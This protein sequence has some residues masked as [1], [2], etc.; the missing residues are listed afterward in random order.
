MTAPLRLT[1]QERAMVAAFEARHG[2]TACP[3]CTFSTDPTE[4]L[5]WREII[6]R[7]QAAGKLAYL[8]KLRAEASRRRAK[9]AE[10]ARMGLPKAEIARRLGISVKTVR[11]D[12]Q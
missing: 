9:V 5:S 8:V 10:L 2:V 11:R 6:R 1:P 7:E 12:M 4:S 3:P